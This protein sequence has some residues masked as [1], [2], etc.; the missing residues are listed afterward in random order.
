MKAF[1]NY[2]QVEEYTYSEQL[3]L[4]AGAYEIKI[5]KAEEINDGKCLAILFD[6]N[7]GKY[8]NYYHNKFANDKK[9]LYIKDAKYKGVFRLFYPN[10]G[11]YDE[12]NERRIKTTLE[13]I[14]RSNP[15]LKVDF[16]QEWDGAILKNCKAGMVF[17]DQEWEYN[18]KSGI[19]TQPYLIISIE[20]YQNGNYTIPDIKILSGTTLKNTNI[21]SSF[22]PID[23][24]DDD[25]PF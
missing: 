10:G 15:N 17:R 24:E 8:D 11:Q 22:T 7:G 3:K 21:S 4:P 1:K 18:D 12:Q 13:N 16:T 23:D 5:L 6:I 9:S 14:K 19:T 20:D 2:N 25:L